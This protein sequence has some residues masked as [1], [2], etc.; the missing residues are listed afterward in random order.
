MASGNTNFGNSAGTGTVGA[1]GFLGPVTGNISSTN[2]SSTG[3]LSALGTMKW[4][5]SVIAAAGASHGTATA[6]PAAIFIRVTATASTEGV[7]FVS[8]V[9]NMVK[10][11]K[12]AA[13]VGVKVYATGAKI[14]GIST[15]TALTIASNKAVLFWASAANQLYTFKGA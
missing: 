7:K 15:N 4:S 6:I 8:I 14:D 1:D 12:A 10:V 9:T 2:L 13:T 3:I 5:G 11:V